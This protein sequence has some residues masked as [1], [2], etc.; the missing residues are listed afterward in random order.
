MLKVIDTPDNKLAMRGMIPNGSIHIM[1]R[2]KR[3]LSNGSNSTLIEQL[4]DP[5]ELSILGLP[6]NKL[7][8]PSINYEV[9]QKRSSEKLKR[10]RKPLIFPDMNLATIADS[11]YVEFI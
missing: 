3:E 5:T 7:R 2:P 8:N 11:P 10:V 9:T 1:N 6:V 4:T